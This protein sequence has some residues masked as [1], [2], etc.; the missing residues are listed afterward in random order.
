MSHYQTAVARPDAA[1]HGPQLL[2]V[3]AL[4]DFNLLRT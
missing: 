2:H 4:M 3:A 1:L